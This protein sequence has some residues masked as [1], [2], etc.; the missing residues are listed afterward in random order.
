M[1][2]ARQAAAL[3]AGQNCDHF[4]YSSAPLPAP[5]PRT[6]TTT[7]TQ[8]S[9]FLLMGNGSGAP[10]CRAEGGPGCS[11]LGSCSAP[12]SCVG[13]GGCTLICVSLST[14][15]GVLST[16]RDSAGPPLSSSGN[17]VLFLV[18]DMFALSLHG[19]GWISV[20]SSV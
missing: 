2:V 5:P 6:A 8:L 20:L 9:G 14:A 1:A 11:R 4:G 7:A 3:R 17:D 13:R 12:L 16:F 19:L 18:G 10:G 15:P